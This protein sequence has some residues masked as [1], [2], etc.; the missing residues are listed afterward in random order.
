ME[1][2]FS[3]FFLTFASD[4]R[5]FDAHSL[6]RDE[7]SASIVFQS[8]VITLMVEHDGVGGGWFCRSRCSFSKQSALHI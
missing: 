3:H 6:I 8:I 7:K 4:L 1:F 2:S 5:H